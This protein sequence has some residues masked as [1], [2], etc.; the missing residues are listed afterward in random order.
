MRHPLA[1]LKT[2]ELG[3]YGWIFAVTA[4]I[5]RLI[6]DRAGSRETVA[7]ISAAVTTGISAAVSARVA[8][9]VAAAI[10][11]GI[12]TGVAACVAAARIPAMVVTLGSIGAVW[13]DQ[14][15]RHGVCNALEV[16]VMD[17]TGAGDAFFA[18]VAVG[19]TYG[20]SLAASCDIGTRLA[21]SVIRSTENT[22]PRFLPEEFGIMLPS[23][24][25][26]D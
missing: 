23:A 11:T 19:L 1:L 16:Q 22:C 18:G 17:T 4:V 3:S 12:A 10:A 7:A 20:K 13:A 8:T 2:K 5:D 9:N 24:Q 14:Q 21:A 25:P 15:G 6:D 26:S